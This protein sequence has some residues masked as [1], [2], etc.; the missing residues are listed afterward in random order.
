[1]Q[2]TVTGE[3][4]YHCQN[5]ANLPML[6]FV[7]RKTAAANYLGILAGGGGSGVDAFGSCYG[8][9]TLGGTTPTAPERFYCGADDHESP[10]KRV[11]AECSVLTNNQPGNLSINCRNLTPGSQGKDLGSLMAAFTATRLALKPSMVSRSA[12]RNSL[13]LRPVEVGGDAM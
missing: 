8:N 1:M 7:E 6:Y 12:R 2:N 13:R 10:S 5:Y 3:Y 4:G 11:L 9:G